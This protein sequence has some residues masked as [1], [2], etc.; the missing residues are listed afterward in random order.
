MVNN[1]LI[2]SSD[3]ILISGISQGRSRLSYWRT[4]FTIRSGD[5]LDWRSAIIQCQR[6]QNPDGYDF[7]TVTTQVC[8]VQ[9]VYQ[10]ISLTIGMHVATLHVTSA[11]CN[12]VSNPP[13]KTKTEKLP[14]HI[15][16]YLRVQLVPSWR[17]MTLVG[18]ID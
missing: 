4:R 10:Y 2:R 6:Y 9:Y 13:H 8:N 14:Q 15:L 5:L 3:D 11:N 7:V 16:R 12:H 1:T 18:F 17:I